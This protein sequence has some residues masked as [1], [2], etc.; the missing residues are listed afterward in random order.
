MIGKKI[1]ICGRMK[2]LKK[3]KN[4]NVFD[5]EHHT[6]ATLSPMPMRLHRISMVSSNGL[7]IVVGCLNNNQDETSTV[8]QYSPETDVWTELKAPN[9]KQ[10]RYYLVTLNGSIYAI[11]GRN[12]RTVECYD[13]V[14]NEWHLLASSEHKHGFFAATSH[15][16]RIYVLGSDNFEV[17]DPEFNSWKDLPCIF[18]SLLPSP[19][20][21]ISFNDK[22]LLLGVRPLTYPLL[23]LRNSYEFDT[24]NISWNK[25]I[26]VK[27]REP[28][29]QK[30]VVVN[31]QN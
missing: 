2:I 26:G 7:L 8:L 27:K 12:T 23:I 31:F 21:L 13:S 22:L 25:L 28:D 20:S 1:F 17:F 3:S 16:N 5:C 6:W 9:E 24:I 19:K 15:N 10:Y 18:P 14:T 11:G 4:L 30:V 29:Y